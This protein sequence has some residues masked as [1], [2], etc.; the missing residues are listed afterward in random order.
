MNAVFTHG[1]PVLADL[2]SAVSN[3]SSR[4]YSLESSSSNYL[5]LE[6]G[7]RTGNNSMT[8]KLTFYIEAYFLFYGCTSASYSDINFSV[9]PQST[10]IYTV[11]RGYCSVSWA[12][13]R[14]SITFG[15]PANS[16][17]TNGMLYMN[18][19]SMSYSWVAIGY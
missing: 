1:S 14:K 15:N 13:N 16:N 4:V 7:T 9:A 10:E 5:R 3:L 19:A 2:Q 8:C 12:S 11:N 17:V 6:T 18:N